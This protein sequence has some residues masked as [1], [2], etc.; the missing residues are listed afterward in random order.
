MRS[1]RRSRAGAGGVVEE[2]QLAALVVLS[3][4]CFL[5]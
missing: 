5:E 1:G 3:E 4:V 2:V